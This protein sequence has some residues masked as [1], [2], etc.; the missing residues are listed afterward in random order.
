MT[1]RNKIL[2][3]KKATFRSL[4]YVHNCV[5]GEANARRIESFRAEL[6]PVKLSI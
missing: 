5:A 4:L 3:N 6:T 1:I 2:G